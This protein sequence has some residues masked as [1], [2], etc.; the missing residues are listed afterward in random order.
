[1]NWIKTLQIPT[2][3]TEEIAFNLVI[4]SGC[5]LGY[6][7]EVTQG[8]YHLLSFFD[9]YE[10]HEP[11]HSGWIYSPRREENQHWDRKANRFGYSYSAEVGLLEVKQES[12]PLR[13]AYQSLGKVPFG[14]YKRV[15]GIFLQFRNGDY[16]CY[17]LGLTPGVI[18]S[19][20]EPVVAY[21]P[22]RKE[23][24]VS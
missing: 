24:E 20:Y 12:L 18:K 11:G 8:C 4:Q 5:D 16:C 19:K 22:W 7:E 3:N 15:P 17:A 13:E 9:S 2:V 6:S 1:M 14:R 21:L 23:S 10:I